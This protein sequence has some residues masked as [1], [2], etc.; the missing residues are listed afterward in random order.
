MS[1]ILRIHTGGQ[2]N[3]D[4]WHLSRKISHNDIASIQDGASKGGHLSLNSVPSPLA[5]M[6]LFETAFSLVENFERNGKQDINEVYHQLASD[7]FDVLEL[8]FNWQT[9]L[10]SGANLAVEVWDVAHE[11]DI[12]RSSAVPEHSLVGLTLEMFFKQDFPKV[13]QL[14]IFKLDDKPFGG[15]SPLTVVFTTPNLLNDFTLKNPTNDGKAYF[16]EARTFESRSDSF[17][18]FIYDEISTQSQ[19]EYVRKY[20]DNK[21]DNVKSIKTEIATSLLK[22]SGGLNVEINGFFLKQ[23][24][25][26]DFNQNKS[27]ILIKSAFL[28]KNL[29]GRRPVVFKPSHNSLGQFQRGVSMPEQIEEDISQRIL[30]DNGVNYP[31]IY[32]D[33]F[34]ENH[35]IRLPYRLNDAKFYTYKSTKPLLGNYDYLLPLKD[36]FFQFFEMKDISRIVQVV[37]R[38]EISVKLKLNLE[39]TRG[40]ILTLEKEYLT[41]PSNKNKDGKIIELRDEINLNIGIFPF[42]KVR[43]G[44]TYNSP[45]NDFYKVMMVVEDHNNQ[46]N[47]SDF[48]ID[49]YRNYDDGNNQTDWSI[50]SVDGAEQSV[51]RTDRSQIST[52]KI[53][54]S[55]FTLNNT[56]FDY[57]RMHL[58]IRHEGKRISAVISPKWQPIQTGTK[59]FDIAVDFG[60]TN[61]FIALTDDSTH[62]SRPE[63]FTINESDQQVVML[64]RPSD[65]RGSREI[66]RYELSGFQDST[67][68]QRHEFIPSLINKQKYN[69]PIR[70][71]LLESSTASLEGLEILSNIN[72]AFAYQREPLTHL[73]SGKIIPNLKWEISP[74]NS[75]SLQKNYIDLFLTQVLY[76]IRNKVLLNGGDP[77]KC[78][79]IWFSPLSFTPV[80]KFEYD[81]IWNK[82]F[83]NIL[84]SNGKLSNITES[85]APFY[86]YDRA[87]EIKNST[88]VVTID[89]GG[90]ST[91]YMISYNHIPQYGTSVNFAGNVL[92]GNGYS[93]LKNDQ[94][95]GIFLK[96]RDEITDKLSRTLLRQTNENL[97]SS[98]GSVEI[99][100]FWLANEDKTN[101]SE[102]LNNG[103]MKITYLLHLSSLIYH[104][105]QLMVTKGSPVPT[106][107]IFSGN[108]SKYIDFIQSPEVIGRLCAHIFTTIFGLP[109]P[110]P[111]VILPNENRKESTCFGGIFKTE[112]VTPSSAIYLGGTENNTTNYKKY[113]DIDADE[114]SIESAVIQNVK[115]SINTLF[116]LNKSMSFRDYFN[117]PDRIDLVREMLLSEVENNFQQGYMKRR[118][119]VQGH[120][121]VTESLFFYPIIGLI[122]KLSGL[123]KEQLESLSSKKLFFSSVFPDGS[124]PAV[125]ESITTDSIYHLLVNNERPTLAS[126]QLI[127]S[128][129]ASEKAMR[130]V[131]SYIRPVCEFDEYPHPTQS[132]K[133]I[134]SGVAEK[135]GDTWKITQKAVVQFI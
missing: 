51:K 7:C 56:F 103:G 67:I 124:I 6:H 30:P 68:F 18:K 37:E 127:D 11:T 22:I 16:S 115:R 45:F 81:K 86:Y 12:L 3:Q 91:D 134:E 52:T 63:P 117:I 131:E 50:I 36:L 47:N 129:T 58:P 94:K 104:I 135:I 55:Y 65:A 26:S 20:L 106:C 71:S 32:A 77:T 39:S 1:K 114:Q 83:R 19:F 74:N 78:N 70:T 90:G 87:G 54:T 46:Y 125:T 109:V 130:N 42:F 121:E 128:K 2:A 116:D 5:R 17:R 88:S 13:K 60:T 4:G 102:M 98:E 119:D 49:F 38:T 82:L 66:D 34:L 113:E 9:H 10:Q 122:F 8:I 69:F 75:S 14:F 110:S 72:V 112:N 101:I 108:G 105:A 80:A 31:W 59:A 79:L 100:N 64:H 41:T 24:D 123:T 40:E 61:T 132:P 62:R 57:M 53:G 99:M 133:L 73:I 89:I 96:L 118:R 107:I 25:G 23:G 43:T 27:E 35:I 95:N 111:Q 33:D 28:P 120:D 126:V 15:T 21:K 44:E 97:L 48:N 84:K 85:E 92:W 29:N 76:L 93:K